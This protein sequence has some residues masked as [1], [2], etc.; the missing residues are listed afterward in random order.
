MVSTGVRVTASFLK[1]PVFWPIS[2][3]LQFGWFPFILLFL[4]SQVSVP[5]LLVTVPR[6]P[7]TIGII[8]PFV[9]HSF[10]SSQA[11]SRYLSLFFIF[12][13][14]YPMIS[15]NDKILLF[16][17]FSFFFLFFFFVDYH[18][19]WSSRC[20]AEIRILCVSFSRTDSGLCIYQFVRIVKLKLLAQFPLNHRTHQVVSSLCANSLHSLIM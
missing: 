17:R 13:Q 9:F 19:V 3:M 4:S 18:K 15:L 20:L 10:F 14:F 7:F 11:R 6:A 16:G 1:S 12:L 5:N 8:V 2:T